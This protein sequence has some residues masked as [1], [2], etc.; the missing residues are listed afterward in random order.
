M[1]N[2]GI[3]ILIALRLLAALLLVMPGYA[4]PRG[5]YATKAEAEQRA[6]ALNCK[7]AFAIGDRWLPCANERAYH[8]AL[9]KE[10]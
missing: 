6:A 8:D 10:K 4:H 2:L 3:N 9:Q 7:G 1:I 5:L